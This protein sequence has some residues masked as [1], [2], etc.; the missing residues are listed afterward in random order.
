[1]QTAP[2]APDKLGGGRTR[3][4]IVEDEF[5]VACDLTDTLEQLGYVVIDA[6]ATGEEAI[7]KAAAL[8]PSAILMDIRL[9][10][11][12]D[13]IEAASRIRS[14]NNIPIVFLSAHSNEETLQRATATEPFGYLVKPFKAPELRCALEVAIQLNGKLERQVAS[15]TLELE[16]ANQELEAF[17][18]SIAHD[19]RTPLRGIAGFSEILIQ[20]HAEGLGPDGLEHVVTV[21]RAAHHMTGL[22]DDLIGLA[23]SRHG[24]LVR[25]PVDV[26]RLAHEAI[27]RLRAAEPYR[28]VDVDI[29]DAITIQGDERLL[30]VVLDNLLGNA[31]K[32]TARRERAAISVGTARRDGADTCFVRDNGA[33]FDVARADRLFEAFERFHAASE[34]EGTGLGLAIVQRILARHGGRVWADS[35]VGVGTTF[36]FAV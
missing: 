14:A 15:R 29:A 8:R 16:A 7:A 13:G 31:W 18:A 34:F 11:A 27:A 23:R 12:I 30:G 24:E 20:D 6:V 3:I 26:S 25:A 35:E 36:Y 32:Y 1:M 4:L 19:L 2:S 21:Q 28:V 10:G 5:V 9:A 33:G 22:I 17:S